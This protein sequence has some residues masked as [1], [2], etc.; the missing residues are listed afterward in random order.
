MADIKKPVLDSRTN[1]V[2]VVGGALA[3]AK[4]LSK[5]TP[6]TVIRHYTISDSDYVGTAVTEYITVKNASGV[7]KTTKVVYTATI[8]DDT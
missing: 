2:I 5:N 3:D 8:T 7:K 1:R 4:T 6:N